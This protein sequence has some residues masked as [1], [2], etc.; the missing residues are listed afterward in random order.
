MNKGNYYFFALLVLSS[1]IW[2]CKKDDPSEMQQEE[3]F[4]EIVTDFNQI[5]ELRSD[6]FCL[7]VPEL[8]PRIPA[9]EGPTPTHEEDPGGPSERAGSIG[10]IVFKDQDSEYLVQAIESP[11]GS[12]SF[13]VITSDYTI[14]MSD[15]ENELY[16]KF[17]DETIVIPDCIKQIFGMDFEKWSDGSMT[18]EDVQATYEG[19]PVY[20]DS[21]ENYIVI[22]DNIFSSSDDDCPP[23]ARLINNYWWC[24]YRISATTS[25]IQVHLMEGISPSVVNATK[26]TVRE[27]VQ[28]CA[29]PAPD[30]YECIDQECILNALRTSL[31]SSFAER[32]RENY[33]K[34]YLRLT[35]DQFE[36]LKDDQDLFDEYLNFYGLKS[37]VKCEG[38]CLHATSGAILRIESLGL[39]VTQP[40]ADRLCSVFSTLS[41]EDYAKYECL[42]N[43]GTDAID[44]V[45]ASNDQNLIDIVLATPCNYDLLMES[46]GLKGQD[47]FYD[48]G[49]WENPDLQIPSVEIPKWSDVIA[50][51]PKDPNTGGTLYGA[52]NIYERVGGPAKDLYDSK[53]S[54]FGNVCAIKVC[55][56]LNA[57]GVDIPE[58][59]NG[60]YDDVEYGTVKGAD[61]KNYFL[62]ANSLAMWMRKAFGT[63]SDNYHFFSTAD[64][65]PLEDEFGNTAELPRAVYMD[66]T[67]LSMTFSHADIYNGSCCTGGCSGNSCFISFSTQ[68]DFWEL[69]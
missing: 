13:A 50:G 48:A 35:D 28:S 53:P 58:I 2:S 45:F 40:M 29:S 8:C 65:E 6:D 68:A 39:T 20:E 18:L 33:L 1:L 59:S 10:R 22:E 44:L 16:T 47:W 55:M 51:V 42:R 3:N 62:N 69:N 41:E 57:A 15:T 14:V 24:S 23:P 63:D 54:D 9:I 26:F 30:C 56:A 60:Q 67:G 34:L 12:K 32:M 66:M 46:L 19:R 43:L 61:G 25:A 52:F 64:I 5:I 38:D 11:E 4:S 17:S 36:E 27:A 21:E 37:P 49:F 7:E 31:G